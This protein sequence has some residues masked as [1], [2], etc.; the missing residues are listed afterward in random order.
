MKINRII[1]ALLAVCMLS[2]V[3]VFAQEGETQTSLPEEQALET[4]QTDAPA[5][6]WQ[7]ADGGLYYY[8]SDGSLAHDM[9][10]GGGEWKYYV[11][12]TGRALEGLQTVDGD[13]YYF[14]AF[15][16][17]NVQ[18]GWQTV[19]GQAMYFDEQAGALRT[20]A[21]PPAEQAKNG[22]Q[23]EN[24]GL[25]YYIDGKPLTESWIGGGEWKYYVDAN[26]RALEGLQTVGGDT[27]Y[28]KAF[29]WCNVQYGWQTVNGTKMYFDEQTGALRTDVTSPAEQAKNGWQKENGGLYYYV[30]GKP[31]TESWIGG[32][33]WKY[34]VDGTGRALEGLQTVGSD[35]YYFKAFPWC[36]VQYGWQTVN[37]QAMY[38]DEETGALRTDQTPPAEETK[39]GWQ[40]E[41]GGLYYY[42]N[43]KLLT[44]SWI[45]GGAWKYYVDGSGRA[46]EGLQ[47]IEGK[48]YYFKPY[49]WCN[50]Q[51][52]KQTVDGKELFFDETTGALVTDPSGTGEGGQPASGEGWRDKNGGLYY[53]TA[54]G[55]LAT[56]R[57]IGSGEWKYYVDDTGR[58]L[59]GFHRIDGETYYFKPYPWCTVQYGWQAVNGGLYYLGDDGVLRRGQWIGE[60]AWK[61]YVDGTGRALEGLR[62]ING[63][64]YYFKEF[65]WCNLQY[66]T[67]IVNGKT[68]IF[69]DTTGALISSTAR[70]SPTGYL[71][72]G[73][74][75][76]E[77]QM[78][79][80]WNQVATS[81]IDYAIIRILSYRGGTLHIDP[82]F[83]RNVE[84]ARNAGLKVGVYYY[85]YATSEAEVIE[86]LALVRDEL[87]KVEKTGFRFDY[88]IYVD[89]EGNTY[90]NTLT[91]QR[92][93]ELVLYAQAILYQLGYYGGLYTY[94]NYA[95]NSLDMN[96][97]RDFDLWLAEYTD[98]DRPSYPGP[99]M[100]WQYTSSGTMPG[101][102]GKVDKNYCYKD[103]ASIIKQGKY[104]HY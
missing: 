88:P 93:T 80:D 5:T 67:Q 42:I 33:E 55:V 78:T 84:G 22:W 43:G 27:Y 87:A 39:N 7:T 95:L 81:G 30:D 103:Y 17:C 9:W 65:P 74:D 48:T 100:A 53:Y 96:Q 64:T 89:I 72:E 2:G 83:E 28:F 3:P 46:V 86:E 38:F 4:V 57:W 18:Y 94:K 51:Y 73:I 58:A 15:P 14:K 76:S 32:G 77:Y 6:G 60:G 12:G 35:T 104:N 20:D 97:L 98:N 1:A 40:T 92:R 41:D 45:G 70:P 24:G 25:Y 69:D 62:E 56:N 37:G 68:M 49:P 44:E 66:G 59:E 11:D 34:Y 82:Y 47:T 99:Y 26:G 63:K 54:D 75:V 29:P 16:W 19:N 31:L 8:L 85:T 91:T 36:N 101:I 61:Y 10:I 90:T 13:T 52:G 21:A 102:S 79:I 71:E 50:V 23:K